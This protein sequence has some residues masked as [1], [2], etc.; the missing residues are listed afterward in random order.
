M[1]V[2]QCS[3]EATVCKTLCPMLSYRTVVLSVLSC[4]VPCVT[5]VYRGQTVGRIKIKLGMQVWT[6]SL[7]TL[8]YMGIVA[9]P[10][11]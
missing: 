5:L 7:A 10:L 9:V 11:S 6:A 4:L 2:L 3:I 8:C 1:F